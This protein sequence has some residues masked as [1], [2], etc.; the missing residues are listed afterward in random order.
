MLYQLDFAGVSQLVTDIC[1]KRLEKLFMEFYRF[2]KND[3]SLLR[4]FEEF[5]S[6][7]H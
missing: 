6:Y 2:Q 5:L 3:P 1:G 7:M 4:E